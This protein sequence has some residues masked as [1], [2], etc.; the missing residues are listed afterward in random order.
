MISYVT[1]DSRATVLG[2]GYFTDALSYGLKVGSLVVVFGP[3]EEPTGA[4]MGRVSSIDDGNATLVLDKLNEVQL[5]DS[6]LASLALADSAVQNL[7]DLGIT[8]TATELN[9]TDGVT[10]ALQTQI[11][12]KLSLFATKADVEA[13][14]IASGITKLVILG[15]RTVGDGGGA[16]YQS[17]VSEPSHDLKIQSADG[18][19]WEFFGNVLYP[20][21]AGAYNDDTNTGSGVHDD[22]TAFQSCI[23]YLRGLTHGGELVLRKGSGYRITTGLDCHPSKPLAIR[24]EPGSIV[25][26]DNTTVSDV[27][28]KITHPTDPTTRTPAAFVFRGRVSIQIRSNVV[29]SIGPVLVEARAASD[30]AVEG[31]LKLTHYANNTALR[32]SDLW[33]VRWLGGI[34]I[35]GAGHRKPYRVATGTFSITSGTTSL[36]SSDSEFTEDDEGHTIVLVN[37]SGVVQQFTL[38]TYVSASSFTTSDTAVATFSAV[39][40]LFDHTKGTMTNGSQDIVLEVAPATTDV[41]RYVVIPSGVDLTSPVK[42][43]L[44]AKITAV[45]TGTKTITVDAAA[46]NDHT[47]YVFFSPAFDMFGEGSTSSATTNDLRIVSLHIEQPRGLPFFMGGQDATT[48]TAG[49]NIVIDWLKLHGTNGEYGSSATDTLAIINANSIH[50]KAIDA[51]GTCV[52]GLGLIHMEGCSSGVSIDKWIGTN[53]PGMKAIDLQNNYPASVFQIGPRLH[54]AP[55]FGTQARYDASWPAPTSG[56]GRLFILG[57][58][59]S[60]PNFGFG[61]P[62]DSGLQIGGD[63]LRRVGDATDDEDAVNRQSGDARY[64]K[65]FGTSRLTGRWYPAL[66]GT[67]ERNTVAVATLDTVLYAYPFEIKRPITLKSFYTRVVTGAASSA[68]KVGIWNHDYDTERPTGTAISGL[69]SNTGQSTTTTNT[70]AGLGNSLNVA[71]EPGWYWFGCAFTTAA[72]TMVSLSGSKPGQNP[73]EALIGRSAI[74]NSVQVCALSTPFTYSSDIT[75]LDLTSVT[76]TDVAGDAGVPILYLGT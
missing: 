33:N 37:A 32:V 63:R 71:L 48:I 46:P 67:Y 59:G 28:F 76:W 55:N 50:I 22:S 4:Y 51:E 54:Y 14:T 35:W 26:V 44:R 41:G 15:Y 7:S 11:D 64:G 2:A 13:A 8:A 57:A 69:V 36:T 18:G 24:G 58:G 27:M 73:I 74:A 9:Y 30:F 3:T 45:D 72:P 66:P 5:D 12:G 29:G 6:I 19:W 40:G 1:E 49:T 56:S 53:F 17:V 31:N 10:S 38:E 23:D 25:Y 75:A 47:G 43:A 62:L 60:N 68:V 42:S 39:S 65:P 52:G 20:E 61:T 16:T 34:E 21:H 70:N